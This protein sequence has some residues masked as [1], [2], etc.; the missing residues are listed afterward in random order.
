MTIGGQNLVI[1]V[2]PPNPLLYKDLRCYGDDNKMGLIKRIVPI[3]LLFFEDNKDIQPIV[4][5]VIV[6]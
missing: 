4:T 2:I 5:Y 6:A 3:V 1:L